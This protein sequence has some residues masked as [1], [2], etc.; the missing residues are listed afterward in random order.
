[1]FKKKC[2]CCS[3]NNVIGLVGSQFNKGDKVY[4]NYKG[5]QRLG[6]IKS[7]N[8]HKQTAIV[9]FMPNATKRYMRSSAVMFSKSIEVKLNDLTAK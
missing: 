5:K 3:K 6:K 9:R 4:F 2:Y 8:R 1:M 7:I